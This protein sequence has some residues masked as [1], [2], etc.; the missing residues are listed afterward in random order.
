MSK[1]IVLIAIKIFN[2]INIFVDFEVQ[3]LQFQV[4]FHKKFEKF[5]K[6]GIIPLLIIIIIISETGIKGNIL[7][8][9]LTRLI[10]QKGPLQKFLVYIYFQLFQINRNLGSL[11]G[12]LGLVPSS[13]LIRSI[14]N[15][16]K[17]LST[18]SRRKDILTKNGN[19]RT[20]SNT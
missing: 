4:Y 20:Q 1:T 11:F 3:M 18:H 12:P 15:K 10:M 6:S 8:L 17:V 5:K 16:L 7:D 14:Q 19:G 13:N 2:K 9:K